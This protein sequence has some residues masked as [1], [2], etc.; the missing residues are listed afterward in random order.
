MLATQFDTSTQTHALTIKQ[1][2]KTKPMEGKK[3][4]KKENENRTKA[5]FLTANI[6]VREIE[7]I[8]FY[9]YSW[10]K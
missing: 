4:K 3:Q 1:P 9:V 2:T 8:Q 7:N 10:V 5:T 6:S